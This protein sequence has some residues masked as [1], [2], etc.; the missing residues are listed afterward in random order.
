MHISFID[1]FKLIPQFHHLPMETKIYLLKNNFTQ[2]FRLNNALVIHATDTTEDANTIAL[3][4]IFP[5][6]LFVELCTCAQNIF[7]FVY[8]PIFLK[9]LFVILIFSSGLSPRCDRHEQS[10][11]TKSIYMVQNFYVE[12]FWRYLCDRYSN[13]KERVR[14]FSSFIQR[15]LRSQRVHEKLAD[16]LRRNLSKEIDQVELIIQSMWF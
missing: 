16:F 15:L 10:I 14:M 12:I 3:R 5:D 11:D 8:D 9:I 1:Y 13:E 6:D 4:Q 7:P 2:V